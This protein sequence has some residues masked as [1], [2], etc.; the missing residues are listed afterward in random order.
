MKFKLLY[1]MKSFARRLFW[2]NNCI[3]WR[4]QNQEHW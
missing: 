3:S 2:C 1:T 4:W